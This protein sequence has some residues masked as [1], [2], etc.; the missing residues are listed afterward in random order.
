[1][2]S[3]SPSCDACWTD[4][5]AEYV[6]KLQRGIFYITHSVLCSSRQASQNGNVGTQKSKGQA[7]MNEVV[8]PNINIFP[9]SKFKLYHDCDHEV[10]CNIM[11]TGY[12]INDQ[13]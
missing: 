4:S 11:E 5:N 7:Q 6:F 8:N 3:T 12:A 2:P 10:T 1:M 9:V 13:N